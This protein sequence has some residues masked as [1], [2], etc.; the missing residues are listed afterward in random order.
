ML[1]KGIEDM[2]NF[3]IKVNQFEKITNSALLDIWKKRSP[4]FQPLK[5]Q[6][7]LQEY[8]PG[9]FDLIEVNPKLPISKIMSVFCYLQIETN[10]LKH[11]IESRFF[12]PLILFGESGLVYEDDDE[13]DG[14]DMELE[15]SRS[16][17]VFT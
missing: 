13:D 15:M 12:D 4:D 5:V 2:N 1:E 17:S 6:L 9:L 16:L 3:F 10:N 14:G 7:D 8:V 11:E